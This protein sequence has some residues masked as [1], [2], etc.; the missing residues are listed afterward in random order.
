MFLSD[1]QY[2]SQRKTR[3][4]RE[5]FDWNILQVALFQ[6]FFYEFVQERLADVDGKI[7][8]GRFV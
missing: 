6:K 1:E 3:P 2:I 5:L 8:F 4:Q 7:P